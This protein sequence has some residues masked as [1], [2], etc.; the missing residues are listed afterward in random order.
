MYQSVNLSVPAASHLINISSPIPAMPLQASRRRVFDS[1][2]SY[3][4]AK[5][6]SIDS[7][8]AASAAISFPLDTVTTTAHTT[9]TAA[10]GPS[11]AVASIDSPV[12]AT[13]PSPEAEIAYSTFDE[14]W[15]SATAYLSFPDKP[16]IIEDLQHHGAGAGTGNSNSNRAY[17]GVVYDGAVAD[18]IGLE[19]EEMYDSGNDDDDDDDGA[20]EDV[21]RRYHKR[22]PAQA[23]LDNLAFVSSHRYERGLR[24]LKSWFLQEVRRHFLMNFRSPLSQVCHA[25]FN[26]IQLPLA[27]CIFHGLFVKL[28]LR[29]QLL[30]QKRPNV[31]RRLVR[32]LKLAQRVYSVAFEHY[33]LPYLDEEDRAHGTV[34]LSREMHSLFQYALPCDTISQLLSEEIFVKS[35]RIL[36]V[37]PNARDAPELSSLGGSGA[38]EIDQDH[39]GASMAV[40]TGSGTSATILED[41]YTTRCTNV[42]LHLLGGLQDVGFGGSSAQKSFAHVMN[43][44]LTEFV[45]G[46]YSGRWESPSHN[47]DHLLSWLNDGFTPFVCSVVGVLQCAPQGSNSISTLARDQARWLDIGV[48]RLGALRVNELF[49]VIVE[50]DASRGAIEDLKHYTTNPATRSHLTS[51]FIST[52]TQRLLQPGASTIEILQMYVS[53]IRSFTQLDKRGV[54][55][56]RIAKPIR[57]YLRERDDTV[58][59]VVNALLNNDEHMKNA[60]PSAQ[61][62]GAPNT[63]GSADATLDLSDELAEAHKAASQNEDTGDLDWNDMNWQPDPIDAA[64]DYKKSKHNDVIGSLVSLFESKDTFVEEL[65]KV[66]GERLLR[67]KKK[68]KHE[69]ESS[70]LE[71]MKL[72]FGDAA[73]QSCEV[74]LRDVLDFQT[75]DS[76]IRMSPEFKVAQSRGMPDFRSRVLSHHYWPTLPNRTLKPPAPVAELQ[77]RYEAGFERLKHSRKLLWVP[78]LGQAVVH[79]ELEDRTFTDEVAPW[80]ATVI[81]AFQGPP[82]TQNPDEGATRTV[83]D[84]AKELEMSEPLV[85]AACVFWAK[86][87]ILGEKRRDVYHVRENLAREDDKA[88]EYEATQKE[89][90][91]DRGGEQAEADPEAL[92]AVDETMA[93]MDLYWQFIVGMLT[94]QG[95]MPLQRITMML[96]MVVPG[97]FPFKDEEL[98]EF[99]GLMITQRR[100]ELAP[101]GNYKIVSSG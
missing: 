10:V 2:F 51:A 12:H 98:R 16:L 64:A 61:Q 4:A 101:G 9:G 6:I 46:S 68:D 92:A 83:S 25:A 50:W 80:Q 72:R 31:L 30:S 97:G 48:S 43:D 63:R 27:F 54:L 95:A 77:R 26:S 39:D 87:Q 22:T 7:S 74:M 66:L 40:K 13:C 5:P 70:V 90:Q 67:G 89:E 52:V 100:L 34:Q 91:E 86:K 29:F 96:R 20:M 21:Y 94:N 44:L 36:R 60:N 93:K 81:Y 42:L 1:V 56:D 71:L 84:L 58:K 14:A 41:E 65:R 45:T 33:V 62:F 69:L 11:A 49:D 28:T 19:C 53:I 88:R 76:Y 15:H 82:N 78:T 59:V 73:L 24:D 57:R 99:L 18:D 55:L 79:L 3:P 23:V 47:Q 38:M 17:G 37:Y 75:F 8:G 35:R 85:R 32:Y